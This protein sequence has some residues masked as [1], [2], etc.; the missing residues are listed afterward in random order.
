MSISNIHFTFPYTF[1]QVGPS[2][3][4]KRRHLLGTLGMIGSIGC[5]N[6]TGKPREEQDSST[7]DSPK[8]DNRRITLGEIDDVSESA[9]ISIDIEQHSSLVTSEELP[10][11]DV[12]TTN[13]DQR[14]CINI[15]SG[16]ECCLFNREKAA[17][18]PSGLWFFHRGVGVGRNQGERW[19]A[20]GG[21]AD[22]G[23]G[24]G[25][26]DPGESITNEYRTWADSTEDGYFVP[27]EYRFEAAVEIYN[28]DDESR[29][30]EFTWGFTVLVEQT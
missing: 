14:K 21:F 2:R 27:G 10:R 3:P 13:L 15:K 9:E 12:T 1:P 18:S 23:C 29:I 22:Y 11:F 4:M 26:Y 6:W 17:S 30:K 5:V 19:T 8:D 25:C 24:R 28:A 16:H 20:S 7:E